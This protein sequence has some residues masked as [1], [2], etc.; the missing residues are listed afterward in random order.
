MITREK[1]FS[2]KYHNVTACI[3]SDRFVN[4]MDWRGV[5]DKTTFF[6]PNRLFIHEVS[7]KM[8]QNVT[9]QWNESQWNVMVACEV[10]LLS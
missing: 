4:T 1:S 7:A 10:I 6:L 3:L 8:P 9:C 5:K 2:E